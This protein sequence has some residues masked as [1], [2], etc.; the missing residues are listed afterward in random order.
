MNEK[1]FDTLVETLKPV[2]DPVITD[3]TMLMLVIITPEQS[4]TTVAGTVS[5]R[6]LM[7]AEKAVRAA[8]KDLMIKNPELLVGLLSHLAEHR[9]EESD[10]GH[11]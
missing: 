10:D 8:A 6:N 7:L 2:V 9:R 4:H 1:E 5:I 11:C 3:D